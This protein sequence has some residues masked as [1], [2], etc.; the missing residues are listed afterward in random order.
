MR[1]GTSPHPALSEWEDYLY[2]LVHAGVG[3][4]KTR[5]GA[6]RM[7]HYMLTWEDSFGMVL[8]PTKDIFRTS[9][10]PVIRE[11]FAQGGLVEGKHWEY[12]K[13]E[14]L[15]TLRETGARC[16]CSSTEEPEHIVG[17]NLAWGWL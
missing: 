8:T 14:S 4:G 5:G 2:A 3:S 13:T 6:Y 12:N 9:T 10:F 16:W 1:Y 15:L 17:Q 11:V 7:L